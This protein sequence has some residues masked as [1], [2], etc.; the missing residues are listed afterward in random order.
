MISVWSL[1]FV[2]CLLMSSL[3][4]LIS[5]ILLGLIFEDDASNKVNAPCA[6]YGLVF[7][8]YL[9]HVGCLIAAGLIK[10]KKMK[11]VIAA[12]KSNTASVV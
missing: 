6:I 8:M 3:W 5:G 9:L 1:L 12:N 7:G 2:A 10:T 11:S 4:G